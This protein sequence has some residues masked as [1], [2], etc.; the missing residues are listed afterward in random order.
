VPLVRRIVELPQ[1]SGIP[2]DTPSR[3]RAVTIRTFGVKLT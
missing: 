1:F 3:G 2:P